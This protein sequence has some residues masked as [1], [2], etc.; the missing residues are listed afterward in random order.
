M[1]VTKF[2]ERP[3]LSAVISIALV[4][5][6]I[7][8]LVTLPIERYPDI[9]PAT[10]MVSTA[11]PGASAET[12]QNSVIAPLEQAING[13]EDMA[14]MSSSATNNG[15]ATISVFFKQGVDPDM[16]AVNVQN[17]INKAMGMLPSEVVQMGVSTSKRQ[18]STLKI[19]SLSSPNNTYDD[20]FLSNYININLQP[21]ILRISGVGELQVMGPDYSMRIWLNPELMA[22]YG[23]IPSDI[24]VLLAEQNI[25]AA[26]GVI[27]ENAK[28]TFQYTMKYSGRLE[29]PEEFEDIVIK[30]LPSGEI[31]HL[32]DVARIELAKESYAFKGGTN[33]SEGITC[34]VSQT[35][36]S[37]A[38]EVEN[39]INIFL[40]EAEKNF[41]ADM[42]IVHLMSS[43]DF[44]YASMNSVMQTLIEAL[45][46]VI[47]VIYV[48][49]QDIRSTL[50]PA[51]AIVVS[52]M[53]T[54][55]F[56][57]L[58]GFS[59]NLL[60][61]FALVL[62]IGVVVDDAIVVV[63]AVQA[64]FDVGYK[65]PFLAS[66]SAMQGLTSAIVSTTL[67][68]LAVFIP[69]SFIGGTSGA[70]YTQFGITM[71]IAVAISA[72]NALTLS[73]ALCALLLKPREEERVKKTVADRMRIAYEVGF[74]RMSSKYLNGVKIV[75]R[76]PWLSW[77]ILVL[78]I[79]ALVL[80]MR[81]TKTGLV[82]S[83]DVGMVFVNINTAP[84]SSIDHTVAILDEV[85]KRLSTIP[86][87]ESYN[88][89]AGYGFISGQGSS[90]GTF[91]LKLKHWDDRKEAHESQSATIG[92]VYKLTSDIKSASIFAFA[93]GM[94]P[95]Y[96]QSGGF[97]MYTQDRKGGSTEELLAV[98]QNFLAE[99][100]KRPEILQAYTSFNVNYP[101]YLVDVDAAMCKKMGIAPN[102]VLSVLG[103]YFGGT[104]ASNFNRFT[105]VYRVMVQASP[106][107][108]ANKEDL[109]NIYV[110]TGTEM[111]PIG[112]FVTLKK[113]YG[114][115][116]LSR[117]NLYS[118]IPVNGMAAEGYSSGDAIR[119]ID[120]VAAET[121]PSGYGYDFGGITREESKSTN[122]TIIIFIV[123]I[124]L[125]YLIL[126]GLY[127]SFF[128]P[129]AVILA[130]P[131]G[132]MG[133]FVFAK[134]MGLEN[135]IYLQ[136]GLI[137]LIGLLGK[138]AILLT[139][140]ASER[141]AAGMT[142]T[143]AAMSAA[144]ARLRPILMTVLTMVF[145]LLPLMF[146]TG[147]G[148]NGNSS[149]GSGVIGG[150]LIGTIS[151]LFVV[152]AFFVAF[153]YIH[154]KMSSKKNKIDVND[155]VIAKEMERL[156]SEK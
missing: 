144:K 57:A 43:N 53:G 145:G 120:E 153:Q 36:G 155:P 16:A 135:N 79:V 103:G 34:M 75:L 87:V 137:M 142:L 90:Y 100:R 85:E 52:L 2:I 80:L 150:M 116:A 62:S 123:C 39:D 56:L 64:R 151:L 82:P 55:A 45:I 138:T 110:R 106:E 61:L 25:E 60:T 126:C 149:L 24:T 146:S 14:Y 20:T 131:F 13:V 49:L 147:V 92:E 58:A 17:R 8:G 32:K 50:I 118:S 108:R 152:P 104:Y 73:P 125:I 117:F 81:S 19:F 71:S 18:S 69:V 76:R 30:S 22:Q 101:Q 66:V 124:T 67:V 46:L 28:Q 139:E 42:K 72:V 83:E 88:K 54:F 129:I 130:I 65:S 105:K 102:Q 70:F 3:V 121:L 40:E 112:Q 63:E 77:T 37:N 29:K 122:N 9:A 154:E 107:F 44:L 89:I 141:R 113:V 111:A 1:N 74:N 12:V 97:E 109:N 41:P 133:S 59:I 96:G 21:E 93:P 27:G 23:L 15:S 33:G 156:K 47:I 38:T 115:E 119:A 91:I 140:F 68:F 127:E 114:A 148:A 5:A 51:I 35:A 48:F 6:G 10:V 86:Q 26:T 94:I 78:S 136:T 7:I 95:G 84:G 11:Y 4:L 134:L 132:L 128:V 143:Q 99:L 31:L 98:T